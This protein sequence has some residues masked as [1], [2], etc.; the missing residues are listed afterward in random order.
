MFLLMNETS[1][2]LREEKPIMN[3]LLRPNRYPGKG[4]RVRVENHSVLRC[5]TDL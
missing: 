3:R 1:E 5:R 4:W 2:K